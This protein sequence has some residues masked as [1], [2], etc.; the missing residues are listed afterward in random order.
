EFPP[1]LE[2]ADEIVIAGV[3]AAEKIDPSDRLDPEKIAQALRERG[4]K[5]RMIEKVDDIVEY[6]AATLAAG[7]VVLV[8]SNGTFGGIHEKLLNRLASRPPRQEERRSS[9]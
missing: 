9:P 4:K 3:F 1:S 8:M 5:A 7:D 2:G 6:L